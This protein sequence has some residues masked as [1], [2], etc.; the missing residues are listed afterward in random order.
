MANR[1]ILVDKTLQTLRVLYKRHSLKPGFF[2]KA[3]LKQGWNVV[4]GTHGQ[5][6]MAMSFAG[7]DDVFGKQQIDV[8]RLQRFVGKDLFSVAEAYVES[9]SWHERSIGVAAMVALS[10]P[11]LTL[12]SLQGRGFEVTGSDTDLASCLQ[13]EDI[14]AVVGY[15]GG[16][17]RLL[18]KCRELHVTDLRPRAD[19]QTMLVSGK[20]I[21][22]VPEEA[23]IHPEGENESV[24]RRA[25]VVAITGSALVN[26][27]FDELLGYARNARL[28]TVYG[29]SAG[30]IPD[31]LF[32]SGVHMVH[33]SRISDADAFERG[34][35][36][37]M[38]MEAVMQSTQQ[39]QTIRLSV[40]RPIGTYVWTEDGEQ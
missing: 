13:S 24:I 34:M 8:Q 4:I 11:L 39:Q 10:Q 23:V 9:G 32:A 16:V 2:I 20:S 17:K 26:G 1:S 18:G 35:I 30:M 36:Y 7:R 21:G 6:G 12:E 14:V 38:N 27:S 19:F 29:A 5:C 33:S 15:G 31:V 37:D 28:V 25:T 40:S 22:F 3:G